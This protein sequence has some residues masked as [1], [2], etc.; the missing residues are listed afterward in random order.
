MA[1]LSNI[2]TKKFTREC[3]FLALF[4]LLQENDYQKI[5]ISQ[6]AEKA[7]VSRNAVYRNFK[8]KDMIIKEYLIKITTD[9]IQQHNSLKINSKEEHIKQLV[10]HLCQNANLAKNLLNA[11]LAHY[12]L[13]AFSIIKGYTKTSFGKN[14]YYENYIASGVLAVFLT[15]LLNDQKESKEELVEI[16]LN[17]IKED[18]V[19]PNFLNEPANTQ[20]R[21]P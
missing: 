16:I 4:Q 6:I 3:I 18:F 20:I 1:Q 13:D 9:Y 12:M 11:G 19:V 17:I 7:G 10:E 15:W 8:C 21:K 5:T 2:E 14:N